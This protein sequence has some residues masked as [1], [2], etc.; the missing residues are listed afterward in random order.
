MRCP[1]CS[2]FPA[3][4][5]SSEPEVE[6]DDPSVELEEKDKT[7]GTAQVNGT[8]RIVLTSECCGE[9]CKETTFDVDISDV[10]VQKV[11][12]KSNKNP[13]GC[14]CSEDDWADSITA[15][16]TSSEITDRS[17]TSKAKTY[18]VGPKKGQTVQVPIPY[19]YQ[20]RY[21]G[22]EAHIELTCAC[23]KTVGEADWQD[24][25]QASGMEELN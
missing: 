20:R 14:T 16:A 7:K 15:E 2:K 19:R 17:E 24:E 23:G 13:D 25:V 11:P 18:K 8:V 12:A 5:T 1:S 9:E 3:F 10:A 4:D 21:Y 6:L 22:A